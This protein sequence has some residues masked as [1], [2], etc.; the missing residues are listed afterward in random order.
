MA[1]VAVCESEALDNV[2][3]EGLLREVTFDFVVGDG[4][5]EFLTGK[6]VDFI[7][8]VDCEVCVE[9]LFEVVYDFLIFR[10]VTEVIHVETKVDW[11]LPGSGV[12]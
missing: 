3:C 6:S 11:I 7:F 8:V 9:L 2:K 12:P 1:N 10:E 4:S 5:M